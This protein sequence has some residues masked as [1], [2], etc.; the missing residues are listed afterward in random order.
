VHSEHIGHAFGFQL[1]GGFLDRLWLDLVEEGLGVRVQ[2]HTHPAEAF[3]SPTDDEWPL[4]HTVG[5]LSLV[6]PNLARGPVG[7]KDA[8]LACIERDGSW[9]ER[10]VDDELTVEP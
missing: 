5:F 3:H 1:K 8:Y 7:F 4:V 10:R 2:V 6:I 9:G